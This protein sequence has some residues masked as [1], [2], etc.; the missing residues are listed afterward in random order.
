MSC[1]G[2]RQYPKALC[3]VAAYAP[4]NVASYMLSYEFRYMA[5]YCLFALQTISKM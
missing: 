1:A 4:F 3:L 5:L 2:I